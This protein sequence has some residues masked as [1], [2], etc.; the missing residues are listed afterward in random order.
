MEVSRHIHLLASLQST[1]HCLG[2]LP[3]YSIDLQGQFRGQDAAMASSH[4]LLMALVWSFEHGDPFHA[5]SAVLYS[6][7]LSF[8]EQPF[9]YQANECLRW[10]RSSGVSSVVV[11]LLSNSCTSPGRSRDH[12]NEGGCVNRISVNPYCN[13][14]ISG[15][16][17]RFYHDMLLSGLLVPKGSP[18]PGRK[19]S[20]ALR[21]GE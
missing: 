17:P 19:K 6:P 1:I 12:R 15:D 4:V 11:S 5:G 20:S 3:D 9:N 16:L 13:A 2:G 14:C 18:F 21:S 8:P 7:S 10:S